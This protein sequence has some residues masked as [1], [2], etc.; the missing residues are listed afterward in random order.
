[1]CLRCVCLCVCD[2]ERERQTRQERRHVERGR[3][4]EKLQVG[5]RLLQFSSCLLGMSWLRIS[6]NDLL[7]EKMEG[8]GKK[9]RKKERER[10]E[11]PLGNPSVFSGTSNPFT[12]CP[13]YP[14]LSLSILASSSH[15][16]SPLR[17]RWKF[18]PLCAT[19]YLVVCFCP[20]LALFL[21][22]SRSPLLLSPSLLHQGGCFFLISTP[23]F[24]FLLAPL[25]IIL[26][27]PVQ[28]IDLVRQCS[29]T[30]AQSN[31]WYS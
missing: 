7:G 10:D 30:A 8:N 20:L 28:F 6:Q 17:F 4:R 23:L 2:T 29:I 5:E 12:S 14:P 27:Q 16:F 9:G 21:V 13:F 31:I 19:F 3:E 26:P 1:M 11:M 24:P 18:S 22:V 25:S 15:L